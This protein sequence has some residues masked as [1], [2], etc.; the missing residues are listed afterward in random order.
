LNP[1]LESGQKRNLRPSDP[2]GSIALPPANLEKIVFPCSAHSPINIF[3][4]IF[5]HLQIPHPRHDDQLIDDWKT[6]YFQSRAVI[7]TIAPISV[8]LKQSHQSHYIC[9]LEI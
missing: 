1:Q 5:K 2:N 9:S 7:A 8:S 4:I 6:S 3:F